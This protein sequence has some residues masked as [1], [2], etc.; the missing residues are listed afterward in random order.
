MIIIMLHFVTIPWKDVAV[1][2]VTVSEGNTG[3]IRDVNVVF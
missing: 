1:V 3:N 2:K